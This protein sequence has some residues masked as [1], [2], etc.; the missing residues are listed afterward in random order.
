M[1]EHTVTFQLATHFL[2]RISLRLEFLF[3]IINQACDESHEVI[4]RFALKNIIELIEIIE[5]PELKSRFIK[6]LIRIEHVLKKQK[7]VSSEQLFHE[8]ETQIHILNHVP[9]RFGTLVFEDEFL[10]NLRQIHHPNTKECE[11]NAPQ[12]V[13]WFDSDPFIRQQAIS[14]WVHCLKDLEYTVS[15]YLALLRETSEYIPITAEKGFYQH[16]FSPQTINHLIL[17]KMDKSLAI[18]PK[19]QLGHNNLSIRLYEL[20]SAREVHDKTVQMEIAFCQ[21]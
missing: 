2:S 19:L 20:A 6:E 3:K 12:L 11:F 13:M 4:H 9:G 16:S 18:T 5:K 1:H 17:L 8:L 14:K 10:K 15:I 21:I 7:L